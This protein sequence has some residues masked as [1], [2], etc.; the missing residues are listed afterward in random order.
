MSAP[1]ASSTL[2][3]VTPRPKTASSELA[4]DSIALS[5]T[6]T[7]TDPSKLPWRLP[8][9]NVRQAAGRTEP[10]AAAGRVVGCTVRLNLAEVEAVLIGADAWDRPDRQLGI[11]H[12]RQNARRAILEAAA[13][14]REN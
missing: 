4:F 14:G 5:S 1:C 9:S 8:I 11:Y 7:S 13:T 12:R 2:S 10:V 3:R 6:S